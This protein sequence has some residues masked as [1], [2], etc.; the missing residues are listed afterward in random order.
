MPDPGISPELDLE[1]ALVGDFSAGSNHHRR[2]IRILGFFLVDN[3]V[4]HASNGLSL[5]RSVRPATSAKK[6]FDPLINPI[7]VRFVRSS[8]DNLRIERANGR[9]GRRGEREHWSEWIKISNE[10]SG[11]PNRRA[12]R[13]NPRVAPPRQ[14]PER[15]PAREQENRRKEIRIAAQMR[16]PGQEQ[17]ERGEIRSDVKAE[18]KDRREGERERERETFIS[19]GHHRWTHAPPPLLHPTS[20]GRDF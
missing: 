3:R 9:K 2:N 13:F 8:K 19:L 5:L 14:L 18:R 12:P 15:R 17:K 10:A 16:S 20:L 4:D 7:P 1:T 6:I 11:V